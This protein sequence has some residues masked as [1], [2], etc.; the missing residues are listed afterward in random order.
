MTAPL[1]ILRTFFV[2]AATT[3]L[4]ACDSGGSSSSEVPEINSFNIY[5]TNQTIFSFNE[6]TR[7]STK[8]AEF[9]D[10]ENQFVELDTDEDKQGYDYAIYAFEM[11]LY[12]L[13][14]DKANRGKIT[15]LT[16]YAENKKICNMIPF[17]TASRDGFKDGRHSNRSTQDLPIITIELTETADNCELSKIQ[18]DKLDFSQIIDDDAFK[19]EIKLT[20]GTTESALGG[21]VIDYASAGDINSKTDIAITEIGNVGILGSNKNGTQLSF[22][23]RVEKDND[24]WSYLLESEEDTTPF[25]KQSSTNHVVVQ[26]QKEVYVL[27]ADDLF[28]INSEDSG[29]P[30]QS[31]INDL[32]KTP[33]KNDLAQNS[34]IETN[35]SQYSDTFLIRQENSLFFFEDGN[36]RE[37]PNNP[38]QNGTIIDFD[39]T[40]DDLALVILENTDNTQ[41]LLVIS[42]LSGEST[43]L[44]TAEQIELH[45]IDN[46]FYINT[47]EL[48]AGS[49]WEAH[50]FRTPTSFTSYS[51]SRFLFA[52]DMSEMH[53]TILILSSDTEMPVADMINP[54]IYVFD[55]SRSNG[56]KTGVEKVGNDTI[57]VD[58]SYGMINTN[59]SEIE[60]ISIINDKY[61]KLVLT[62]INEESGA[63]RI[64]REQYYFDPSEI[65]SSQDPEDQSL[66]LMNREAL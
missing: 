49:G 51:N 33:V 7:I 46:E 3:L 6:E 31:R 26:N 37:I 5:A 10:G 32:F 27:N 8:R 55:K 15:K 38:I 25:I 21:L 1:T 56:R 48:I 4:I 61:G 63:G 50:W 53:S 28:T 45:V 35:R 16:Q 43:T 2:C 47:L 40:N 29:N 14:Y 57:Q 60:H 36:F 62:G 34:A 11:G 52:K 64:V 39:L 58:F 22:N 18:R 65:Y 42:T 20:A 24:S 23:Y 66:R 44:L 54:A 19:N 12:L 41:T 9:D 59:V 30:V 17:K 13:D